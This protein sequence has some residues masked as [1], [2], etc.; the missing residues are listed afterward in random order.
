MTKV[1]TIDDLSESIKSNDHD[2][3]QKNLTEITKKIE[4]DL[5]LAR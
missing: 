3:A 2:Y 4:F 5:K 1:R